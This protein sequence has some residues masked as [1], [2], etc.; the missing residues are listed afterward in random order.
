MK[1]FSIWEKLDF[2]FPLELGSWGQK[3]QNMEAENIKTAE[4]NKLCDSIKILITLE[5]IQLGL[6]IENNGFYFPL[7]EKKRWK[8]TTIKS[9]IEV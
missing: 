2:V 7:L 4:K 8:T 9:G 6:Q 3:I 5:I 1:S